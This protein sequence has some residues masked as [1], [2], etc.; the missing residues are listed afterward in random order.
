MRS[1]P[2]TEVR[3]YAV[4][5]RFS[6]ALPIII[7]WANTPEDLYYCGGLVKRRR[8]ILAWVGFAIVLLSFL[9]YV[10][11]FALFPAT[12]D[13]PWAN[14]LLFAIGAGLLGIGLKRAFSDPE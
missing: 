10:P 6:P 12:R 4:A 7:P 3:S 5:E 2:L 9:S 8:N 1:S 13:V 14:Y 11:F